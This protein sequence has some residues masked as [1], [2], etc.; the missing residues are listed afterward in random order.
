MPVNDDMTKVSNVLKEI[1]SNPEQIARCLVLKGHMG[2]QS[3]MHGKVVS[4][5]DIGSGAFVKRT[6]SFGHLVTKGAP[7]QLGG[8]AMFEKVGRH[9]VREERRGAADRLPCFKTVDALHEVEQQLLVI[10]AQEPSVSLVTALD[11]PRDYCGRVRATINI[12]TQVDLSHSFRRE[13]ALVP[14][15]KVLHAMK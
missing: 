9:A 11:Q 14:V 15:D 3:G 2:A 13:A 5:S 10:S 7:H 6:V 8:G 4:H 1:V 12:V